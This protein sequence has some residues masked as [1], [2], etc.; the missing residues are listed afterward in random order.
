[1]AKTKTRR[2][3]LIFTALL[4]AVGGLAAWAFLQKREPV[5]TVQTD[6]VTRRNLT[7]L[8]VAN[9]KIQPVVQVKI[10]PKSAAKSSSC[11]SRKARP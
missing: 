11:R 5:I 1:M 4:L 2:K 3:A 9:G 6:K 7:E 8:V 10:S